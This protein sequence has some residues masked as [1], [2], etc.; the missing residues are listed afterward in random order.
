V[1][2]G[3]SHVLGFDDADDFRRA[4]DVLDGVNY[5][6]QGLQ[7]ALGKADLME[8]GPLDEHTGARRTRDETPL[9]SLI[10]LFFLGVP[11]P[12]EAVRRAV[13]PMS[14]ESWEHAALL[15]V[16][17]G[18]VRPLVKVNP[19][20]GL[21][22]A[23][24]LRA[25][26]RSGTSAD[27]VLGVSKSSTLVGHTTP[28]GQVRRAL[29]VGTGCGILALLASRHSEQVWA[30][31]KNP[32][33]VAFARFNARLNGIANVEC[34]TG[35]LFEPVTGRRFD[36]VI[37]NPPYVIAP[38]MRYLFSDSGVRG[39]EFC[40]RIVRLG[41]EFLEDGGYCQVMGNWAQRAGQS[42]QDSLAGWFDGTECDVVVWGGETQ[43]A[44]GYAST[45]I[46]QTE[47]AFLD[48]F[49][50]LYDAWMNYYDREGIETVTYGLITLRR[51]G[52]SPNWVRFVKVPKG[53]GAPTGDHLLRRF[54][55]H[56]FLESLV[57]DRQFLDQRF[58]L[59][60]DV[61]LEQHYAPKDEG[62]AVLS[63]RLHLARDPAYY[64]MELDQTVTTLVMLCKGERRLREVMVEMAAAMRVE[65]DQL[66]PGGLEV[67]RQLV[68][69]GYLLPSSG[70]ES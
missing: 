38:A 7:D 40:R 21:V 63:T 69:N 23:A 33:A 66:L 49:P 67:A 20:K 27:F 60:P 50:E 58:R 17:D 9:H 4:R 22:L 41:A 16:S 3:G 36:L 45:W 68:Q 14:V 54:E 53:S 59:A 70:A 24:D 61:R 32:R 26:M 12:L 13:H 55:A 19:Y 46:Q 15:S 39:D 64:S 25:R 18:E 57:D 35:D 43:D 1:S 28:R 42:W 31:D 65:L 11:A 2:D 5:T 10:R 37:S 29:D 47:P 6:E 44:S 48:R 8:I 30:T 62:F 51:S 34:V 56:D 52:R